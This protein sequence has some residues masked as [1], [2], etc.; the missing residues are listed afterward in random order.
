MSYLGKEV[1]RLIKEYDNVEYYSDSEYMQVCME[2]IE[3]IDG[4]I[5]WKKRYEI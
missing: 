3:I 2:H 4:F 5:N 1:L